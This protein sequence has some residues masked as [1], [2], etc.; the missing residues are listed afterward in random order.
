MG[1]KKGSV[2]ILLALSMLM[3]LT[4]CLV[5]TEGARNYFLRVKAQ[6]A[7]ELTEF[8]VLS[9]YQYELLNHYG[10]FFLDL[11]YEQGKEQTGML[12]YHA[13][14]YLQ[15]NAEELTTN[16]VIAG[17]YRRATDAGGFPFF[18]Q[19]VELMKLKS[20]YKVFEELSGISENLGE[21]ADL[22]QV[23]EESTQEASEIMQQY[24]GEDGEALFDISLPEVSFPS[25]DIL[26]EAVFGSVGGLSDKKII[27][28]ERILNRSLNKGI[29]SEE[30]AGLLETQLFHGYLFE[31][32]SHYG[33]EDLGFWTERLEYQL[34]YI[35]AG[36]AEDQKNLED[37]MWRIFLLRAGANYLLFHKDTQKIAE[38]EAEA[39]LLVGITGNAALVH[40]VRE[41][42]LIS[43]AIEAAV[44]ETK[45][46]FAGEKVAL[47]AD[48]L[49][50][51]VKMGYEQYLYLFLNTMDQTT[52]ICRCMDVIE[53]EVREKCGYSMLRLDH[54]VDKFE[55]EW[56]WQF[57]SLFMEI[58]LLEGGI[59]ENTIK[60]QMEYE[61]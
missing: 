26:T 33:A 44:D 47:Y 22:E 16:H 20:G 61:K 58:P 42:L 11:D 31:Y 54:C 23:L 9:E 18:E 3:F 5:L 21:S 56:N 43:K 19:A 57:E 24:T 40:L 60:R 8:S 39:A 51:T 49:L 10:V 6:Q 53:L 41:I 27:L 48:G 14:E 55:L 2:T 7:M 38:A 36:K 17:N 52:K 28:E 34:E 25:I 13:G 15:E 59:Y 37:I 32:M 46:I 35:I 45:S 29:G 50:G 1:T 12:E 30:N 4:F